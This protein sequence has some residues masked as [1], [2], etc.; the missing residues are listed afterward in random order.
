MVRIYYEEKY[1]YGYGNWTMSKIWFKTRY[2]Y[3][4]FDANVNTFDRRIDLWGVCSRSNINF[5]GDRS[6][7]KQI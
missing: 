1:E 3:L 5:N 4:T 6:K 7:Y 2:Y